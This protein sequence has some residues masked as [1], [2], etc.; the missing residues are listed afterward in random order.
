MTD[1]EILGVSPL[2]TDEEIFLAYKEKTAINKDKKRIE[3]AFKRL[4][5]IKP[6]IPCPEIKRQDMIYSVR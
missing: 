2:A 3:L 1:Y 5:S 4:K 6:T